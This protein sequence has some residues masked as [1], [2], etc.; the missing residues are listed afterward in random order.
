MLLAFEGVA[1]TS[2]FQSVYTSDMCRDVFADV[3]GLLPVLIPV[4]F[5]FIAF[6]KGVAFVGSTTKDLDKDGRREMAV[7]EF[8]SLCS[9]GETD[10][11]VWNDFWERNEEF[12]K[13]I[14][15]LK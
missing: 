10:P 7:R 13:D 12:S 5:I 14:M 9:S 8:E 3:V 15:K 4:M 1:N 2:A 6:R 11:Y